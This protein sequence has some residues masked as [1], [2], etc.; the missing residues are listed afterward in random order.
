MGPLLCVR[1]YTKSLTYII[2]FSY[3]V[4]TIFMVIF[5]FRKVRLKNL[6]LFA[7]GARVGEW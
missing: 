5:K 3:E 7:Q 4:G 6:K 2:L 1:D